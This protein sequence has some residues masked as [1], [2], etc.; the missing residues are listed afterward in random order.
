[1]AYPLNIEVSCAGRKNLKK[2]EPHT[3]VRILKKPAEYN[4]KSELIA[5]NIKQLADTKPPQ[6]RLRIGDYRAVGTVAGDMLYLH[7]FVD[8]KNL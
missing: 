1:M 4:N 6:F 8:R 5:I 3:R 2:F 7:A